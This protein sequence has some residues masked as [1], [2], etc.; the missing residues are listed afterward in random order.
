MQVREMPGFNQGGGRD[1]GAYGSDQK[2]SGYFLKMP[3]GGI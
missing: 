3:V 2:Q 1:W